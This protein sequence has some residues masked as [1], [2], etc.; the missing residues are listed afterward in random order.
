M[1]KLF[2]MTLLSLS[3][4]AF[5]GVEAYSGTAGQTL[6]IEEGDKGT[7]FVKFTGVKSPWENKVI[8][9]KKDAT[10]GN[11]Y[12]FG[13]KLELSNGVHDRTYNIVTEDGQTLVAGSIVKKV[14]LW[15][16]ESGRDGVSF[17]WDKELTVKSQ[18]VK[19]AEE[20][21]KKPFTPDVD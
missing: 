8:K 14:R 3:F 20:N 19:L 18:E 17:T 12:Q 10:T 7:Y 5:S 9:A 11:H 1:K 4:S 13:Y 16:Q 21:K 2:A 15:T 6:L